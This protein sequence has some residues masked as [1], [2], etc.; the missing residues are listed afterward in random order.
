MG[1][2]FAT[3]LLL[4]AVFLI[5]IVLVQRGRG[6]GLA[7]ALGGVGGSSAFG[8]K[9]GDMFTRITIVTAAIWIV[10]CVGAVYWANRRT[11]RLGGGSL[12]EPP[13]A[14]SPSEGMPAGAPGTL[15]ATSTPPSGANT[16]ATS[17]STPTTGTSAPATPQ[18][19]P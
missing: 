19:S 13:P 7:G 12:V 5:L 9:A 15:P 4:L 18:S 17:S 16:P 8:A 3:V 10:V 1:G 6:G 14:S 2:L 11:D